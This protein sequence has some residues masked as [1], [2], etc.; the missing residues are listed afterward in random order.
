MK[1]LTLLFI[2]LVV[3]CSP[4]KEN[5]LK[6]LKD[7]VMAIHDEVMPKIGDLR[8]V[9]MELES[10][11]DS[12]MATDSTRAM[13][14]SS[15]AA[16]ISDASEGMMMWMRNYEPEFEGTEAEIKAYL[17]GQKVSI[18]KV[19]EDMLESMESGEQALGQ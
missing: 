9:R 13:E 15:L 10:L 8:K 6:T 18:Q 11:S 14:L 17:E 5:E 19:K 2:A 12:L 1:Y 16:D 3:A 4:S 7:E